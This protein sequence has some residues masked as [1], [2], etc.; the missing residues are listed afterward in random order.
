MFGRFDRLN[1]PLLLQVPELVEG[2]FIVV[3]VYIFC[4]SLHNPNS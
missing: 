2:P 4:L 1:G 3:K